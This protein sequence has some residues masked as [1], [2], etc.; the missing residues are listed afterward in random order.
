MMRANRS[1]VA[2]RDRE[3][4]YMPW[5]GSGAGVKGW[6]SSMYARYAGDLM[7]GGRSFTMVRGGANTK[8]T[9]ATR[10]PN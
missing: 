4:L 8:R 9:C 6:K 1:P 5:L 2:L 10:N 3:T 7:A